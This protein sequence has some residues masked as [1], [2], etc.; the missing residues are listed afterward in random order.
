MSEQGGKAVV[1]RERYEMLCRQSLSL[2]ING[3]GLNAP[4][5]DDAN[6][7]DKQETKILLVPP[8]M[9]EGI[10]TCRSCG[11]KKTQSWEKQMRSADEPM[12]TTVMCT[13]C[14]RSWTVGG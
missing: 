7:I 5:F 14:R 1:S 10:Y 11:S 3:T 2:N 13:N 6:F 9:M 8:Q 12:T 4:E